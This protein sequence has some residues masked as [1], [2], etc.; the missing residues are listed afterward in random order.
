MLLTTINDD[1]RV[2]SLV[3]QRPDPFDD[4]KLQLGVVGGKRSGQWK[5]KVDGGCLLHS[6]ICGKPEVSKRC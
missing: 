6:N 5:L 2:L 4:E 1:N 3:H